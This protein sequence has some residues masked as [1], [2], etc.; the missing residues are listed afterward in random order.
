MTNSQ[1]KRQTAL[2]FARASL[3]SARRNFE[4]ARAFRSF[5]KGSRKSTQEI[6]AQAWW[7]LVGLDAILTA[8]FWRGVARSEPDA[9]VKLD[10]IR[11]A[12][13]GTNVI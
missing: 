2:R 11:F 1:K 12:S 9:L 3:Q 4:N 6:S 8:I 5:A 7:T 10:A 13:E